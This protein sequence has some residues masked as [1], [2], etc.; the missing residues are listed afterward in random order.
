[1]P[2]NILRESFLDRLRGA[3]SQNESRYTQGKSWLSDF[4]GST[5]WSINTG[6]EPLE[7]LV[8]LEPDGD[9]L[10]DL[11]N[12]IRLH[13]ALSFL[14][15]VQARDPRLWTYLAHVDLWSY[16][17]KRWHVERYRSDPNK[18]ERFI[19]TRYF[20]SQNQSR[21]FLRNGI[22][23]LW[24]YAR[25]THEPERANPY[26][27]TAVLLDQL[28]ITQTLLERNLGRIPHLLSGFL[29]FLLRHRPELLGSGDGKRSHIR[30][31]AKYL[32]QY[33]GVT[34]LDCL[35]RTE[36]ITLLEEEYA[37]ISEQPELV[38]AD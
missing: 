16:M 30:H 11:Q 21:A 25:L 20:V 10:K 14:T 2:L 7:R 38:D 4:A 12:A 35:T 22:A 36:I 19:V 17:R 34:L 31:L 26:E 18:I 33:G 24:W 37:R 28:D 23:R 27:L 5:H 13:N 15:P 1:M 9:D 8:L 6:L 3:I 32:N 29:D